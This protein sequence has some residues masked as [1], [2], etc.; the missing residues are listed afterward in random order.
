MLSNVCLKFCPSGYILSGNQCN[1]SN[2]LVFNLR[3]SQIKDIVYDS[4]RN[5]AFQTGNDDSFYPFYN[6][7]DPFAA[8]LRGYYFRGTSFMK[9]KDNSPSL[10]LGAEFTISAWINPILDIGYIIS[11]QDSLSTNFITFSLTLGKLCFSMTLEDG[12]SVSYTTTTIS[13]TLGSWNFIAAKSIISPT[14][15]QQI[16]FYIDSSSEISSDLASSWYQD[17]SSAFTI[18]IG[19]GSDLSTNLYKGFLWDVKFFS[20]NEPIISIITSG[21]CSGCSLCPIELS[22]DCIPNCDLPFYP[23]GLSCNSCQAQCGWG[24]VRHDKNCNLCQDVICLVC[25]DYTSTCITCREHTY[26]SLAAVCA[27]Y[28]GYYWDLVNEECTL[29]DF[30]CKTCISSTSGGCLVCA[31]GFYMYLGWCITECPDGFIENGS[32]C[33][34]QDTFIFYLSFDTLEGVVYDKKSKIPAL[35]GSSPE[36]YP[37]Y[38]PF[39]PLAAPYRGFYFNGINSIMHLPI[40]PGYSS[41]VLSFGYSFTFSIW[42]N[43]ENGFGTVVSKQ[44][45]LYNQIF[46]LQLAVGIVKI[47]L[48]FSISSINYFFYLQTLGSYE[49]NH[50]TIAAEY[51]NLK[52]TI[53]AFY[54]N[55]LIDH[56][57]NIGFDYFEDTKIDVTF[58]LGAAKNSLGYSSYFKGFIYDIKGYNSLKSISS[59]ALPSWKCTESC[60]ACLTNGMCISNCLISQYWIGPQYYNCSICSNECSSCRDSSK[61][62]NLCDNPKCYSCTDYAATSCLECISNASNITSC[63]CNYG[64]GWN[65]SL[66]ACEICQ[67]NQFKAN[68]SCFDCPDLCTQ[69]ENEDKCISCVKNAEL[70]SGSCFCP[71]EQLKKSICLSVFHVTLAVNPINTL[72]LSFSEDLKKNLTDIQILVQIHNKTISLWSV[73]YISNRTFLISCDFG[74]KKFK[75]TVVTVLFKDLEGIQSISGSVLLEK[76]LIGTLYNSDVMPEEIIEIKN[77][78][79]AGIKILVGLGAIFSIF[80]LNPSSLWTMLNTIQLLAYIPYA[81]YPITEKISVFFKSMNNFN[82]VPNLF[83]L[84]IEENES[85]SPYSRASNY[86]YD[87][88]LIFVNIGSDATVLCCIIIATPLVYYFSKCSQRYIGKKFKKI[89]KEYKFATF[90]RFW[91]VSYLEFG[92]A[93]IIGIL[94][95]ENYEILKDSIYS[96][97]YFLCWICIVIII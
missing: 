83:L 12:T 24:C 87:S 17:I 32:I 35:I 61:F 33:E 53:I 56:Q 43:I 48:N 59:L 23:S 79:S 73:T 67:A 26:M 47:S 86:G 38:D 96:T 54:L 6:L 36:F 31:P 40:Y 70:R 72:T 55:G 41:P 5:V 10:T 77:Q 16:S 27:C 9:S 37:D 80:S 85:N 45:S 92:F 15:K 2:E 42:I 90:L 7:E 20:V 51:T 71:P 52:Y 18:N 91:I 68:D 84:F 88:Y 60:K 50:I 11:K 69:C 1:L 93:S 89:F 34:E 58:T 97:N 65:P 62:C 8:N 64:L 46:S 14:P 49:W 63:K 19:A 82:I 74:I 95:T 29:C 22:N 28:D 25:D 66:G 3:L 21:T 44:D 13:I 78:V 81:S 94:S 76:Y 30:T 75:K 39:D 4:V 57:A